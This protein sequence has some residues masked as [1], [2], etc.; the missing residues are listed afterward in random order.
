MADPETPPV[1]DSTVSWSKAQGYLDKPIDAH[2]DLDAR[3]STLEDSWL[4]G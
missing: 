1:P 2:H 3:G 4:G